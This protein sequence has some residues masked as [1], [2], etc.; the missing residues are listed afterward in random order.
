MQRNRRKIG[1]RRSSRYRSE[2]R[3]KQME[4]LMNALE[5][6]YDDPAAFLEDFLGMKCD[7]WQE[8]VVTDVAAY[9]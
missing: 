1:K 8:E 3:K 7:S 9:P 4:D 2:G 6:Y 5:V